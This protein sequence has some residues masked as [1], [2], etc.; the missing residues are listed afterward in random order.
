MNPNIKVINEN[1]WVVNFSY[2]T[3]NF[4]RELSFDQST[5]SD[6][7]ALTNDGKLIMNSGDQ[8]MMQYLPVVKVVMSL[9]DRL[10]NNEQG[11]HIYL[12]ALFPRLD[13]NTVEEVTAFLQVN[14]LYDAHKTIFENVCRW[15]KTRRQLKRDFLKKNWLKNVLWKLFKRKGG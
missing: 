5:A 12:K 4:I 9:P 14:N 2:V 6:F 15:E 7:M 8:I 3:M 13:K 1:L 11:L 10:L